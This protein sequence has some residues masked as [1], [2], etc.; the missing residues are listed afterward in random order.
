MLKVM[1][2]DATK[3]GYLVKWETRSGM[4]R[5]IFTSAVGAAA[6]AAKKDGADIVAAKCTCDLPDQIQ[7]EMHGPRE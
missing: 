5:K 4:R 6:F 3:S 2:N 1:T 7:C